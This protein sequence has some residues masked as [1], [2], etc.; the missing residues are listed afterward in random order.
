MK[1]EF[2]YNCCSNTLPHT[3]SG[4]SIIMAQHFELGQSLRAELVCG[5]HCTARW[6]YFYNC[7]FP[8]AQSAEF[9]G[10]L[11]ACVAYVRSGNTSLPLH[12]GDASSPAVQSGCLERQCQVTHGFTLM[13][14]SSYVRLPGRSQ[15]ST[16][17]LDIRL[18]FQTS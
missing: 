6:P 12:S 10:V 17:Y 9:D 5:H 7:I 15:P 1:D 4:L 8:Q 11:D 16:E 2:Q 13:E 3:I 14:E 18:S